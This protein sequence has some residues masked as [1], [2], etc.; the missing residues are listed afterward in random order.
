[1]NKIQYYQRLAQI[2][3]HYK[4]KNTRLPYPPVRLW[5][6]PTN[7][8]NLRCVMCPNKDFKK[9]D[10]GYMGLDLFKKIIDEAAGSVFDVHL[11]HR[12]ESLLHP[13]F[14]QMVRYAHDKGVIT[15]FHTNGTLLNEDKA[16]RLLDSGLDQF[17]FSFDGYDKETYEKIRV[18]AN[19]EKTLGNII[20]FLELKRESGRKKPYTILEL[21]N[22]PDSTIKS[23][24]NLKNE[25]VRRFR[26]LPLDKLEIKEYHNW[27]GEVDKSTN[28]RNYSA[29]TFLWHALIIFWDGSVLPCTQDFFG[30]YTLGNVGRTSLSDIWNNDK[31]IRLREKTLARDIDDL[32]TCSQCDRL[33]REKFMGI[34]KEYLWKFILKK[35][36]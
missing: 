15:K 29:C 16:R 32:D 30:Y 21:I 17:S 31:M 10:K 19:F 13:D 5:I 18:N 23:D 12:G 27:A 35:M 25:F 22:F 11:L 14:F 26:D 36:P 2:F 6:E 24:K 1:M 8:C 28:T 4:R 3:W 33:W 34:P 9:E 20:R 7:H